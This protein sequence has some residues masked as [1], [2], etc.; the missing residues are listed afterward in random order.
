MRRIVPFVLS[1]LFFSV[2]V[3]AQPRPDPAEQ[4][5]RLEARVAEGHANVQERVTLVNLYFQVRN[6]EGRR[7]H[8]L[9]LIENHPDTG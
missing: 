6:I 8:V 4:I 1:P 5:A 3:C 7:Q 2:V 9:W